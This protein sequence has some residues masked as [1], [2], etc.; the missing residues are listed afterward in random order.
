MLGA[1]YRRNVYKH[2]LAA[3]LRLDEAVRL[4]TTALSNEAGGFCS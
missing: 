2:V 3:V 1:L 4:Y